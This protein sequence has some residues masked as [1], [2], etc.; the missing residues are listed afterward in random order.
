MVLHKVMHNVPVNVPERLAEAIIELVSANPGIK[1]VGL[2]RALGVNVKTIGRHVA[3][4]GNK[5]QYRGSPKKGGYYVVEE[6]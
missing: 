6:N 1:R 2:A 5:V 4:L 3:G